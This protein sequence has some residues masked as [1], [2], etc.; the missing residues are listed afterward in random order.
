MSPTERPANSSHQDMTTPLMLTHHAICETLG[1]GRNGSTT[2]GTPLAATAGIA[3]SRRLDHANFQAVALLMRSVS[4]DIRKHITDGYDHT[5][6]EV[7]QMIKKAVGTGT[8]ADILIRLQALLDVGPPPTGMDAFAK[9]Q[10]TTIEPFNTLLGHGAYF[11][12]DRVTLR[13]GLYKLPSP[14][15]VFQ[16]LH[17]QADQTPAPKPV[18]PASRWEEVP[19]RATLGDG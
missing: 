3:H 13:Q 14:T 2:C 15:E 1:A 4:P 5:P 17:T 8:V 16:S 6:A 7:L 9:Y 18:S 12:A 10:A 19:H 11:R